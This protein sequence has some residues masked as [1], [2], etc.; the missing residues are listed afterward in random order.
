MMRP[1]LCFVTYEYPPDVGGLGKSSRRVTDFLTEIADVTVVALSATAPAGQVIQGQEDGKRVIRM[2]KG[3]GRKATMAALRKLVTALDEARPFDLFHGFFLPA[4][5]AFLEVAGRRPTIASIRGNDAVRWLD[6]PRDCAV[7]AEVMARTTMV[8]SVSSDLLGTVRQWSPDPAGLQVIPN[9]IALP[10][11]P[12]RW[13]LSDGARGRVGTV[14]NLRAKKNIPLLIRA[15]AQL[16]IARAKRLALCG[17]FDL[18]PALEGALRALA[19]TLGIEDRVEM[20]GALEPGRAVEAQLLDMHVFV[21]SSD[22]EGFPNSLLEA[23]ALG[24][25]LVS[26][27]V[28][29]MHDVIRPGVNGL[30]VP[31]GDAD[32]MAAAIRSIL[33]DDVLAQSL[34]QGALDLAALLAPPAEKQSWHRLYAGLLRP[35]LAIVP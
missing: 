7:I 33:D 5:H 35:G 29:G 2:G 11:F 20:C 13:R 24:V 12:A 34:S 3:H 14:A 30:L 25:P 31:P 6:L 9:S 10:L 32:I 27:D 1:R 8:T 16:P 17:S 18:E 23:A 28:G 4:A 19:E 15:F 26:T 21:I 22:H